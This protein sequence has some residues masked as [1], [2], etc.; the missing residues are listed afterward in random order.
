M[1]F[2]LKVKLWFANFLFCLIKKETKNQV[3]RF[4]VGQI[5]FRILKEK[6]SLSLKQLFFLR[7]LQTFDTQ[8]RKLRT[9]GT[10][11]KSRFDL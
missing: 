6:N 2:L 9:V 5:S 10:L 8:L 1:T 7:I 3:L 11:K 4:L